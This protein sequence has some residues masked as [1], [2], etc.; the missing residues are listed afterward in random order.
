VNAKIPI[1]IIALFLVASLCANAFQHIS[2]GAQKSALSELGNQLGA[3]QWQ[4]N[5]LETEKNSLQNQIANLT[6]QVLSLQNQNVNISNQCSNISSENINL[7]TE[8]ANLQRENAGLQNQ[9]YEKGPRLITK[10]GATDVRIIEGSTGRSNQ[11]RLFIEGVVWNI[12]A[13][14]AKDCRLHVL[15][16][17]NEE[18]VNNTYIQLGTINALD[19]VNVRNDIY[20]YIGSRLTD[21]KITPEY[22]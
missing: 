15:L 3:S 4:T 21:W 8:C 13:Q 2:D 7:R 18:V 16:F 17:Q 22:S 11:T 6:A 9:L 10:L 19:C 20:Y 1:V 12:G 14:V 5:A